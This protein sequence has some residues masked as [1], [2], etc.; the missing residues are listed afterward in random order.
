MDAIDVEVT[1]RVISAREGAEL[2]KTE[3]A[4]KLGMTKQAY[5]PYENLKTPFSVAQLHVAARVTGIPLAS[6]LGL[7]AAA[8]NMAPDEAEL[9]AAF[10]RIVSSDLRQMAIRLVRSIATAPLTVIA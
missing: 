10:R 8:T 4:A 6:L 7:P 2:T 5:Q 3:F 9:I 1:K